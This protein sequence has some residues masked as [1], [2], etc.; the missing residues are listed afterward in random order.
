MIGNLLTLAHYYASLDIQTASAQAMILNINTLVPAIL[1]G[2][3]V[4][5]TALYPLTKKRYIALTAA[6]EA[7]KQGVP[8]NAGSLKKII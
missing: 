1:G 4:I 5:C 7:K 3:A 6:L 2:I 8:H